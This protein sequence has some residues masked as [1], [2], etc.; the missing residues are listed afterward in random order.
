MY[1]PNPTVN[2]RITNAITRRC[3]WQK[4]PLMLSVEVV[5]PAVAQN[6]DTNAQNNCRHS[7]QNPKHHPFTRVQKPRQINRGK[8]RN[9]AR[10]VDV[11]SPDR[12]SPYTSTPRSATP[13]PTTTKERRLKLIAQQP[14]SRQR[15]QRPQHHRCRPVLLHVEDLP[16][17]CN[18]P[19]CGN[20]PQ[21]VCIVVA[22]PAKR[23]WAT[24]PA[25]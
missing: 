16:H 20:R 5:R 23:S 22:K 4:A 11:C 3:S 17:Q 1:H 24:I 15:T 12:H 19:T 25:P 9:H 13:A 7:K 18:R 21:R 10:Q 2:N 14:P 8:H 6:A